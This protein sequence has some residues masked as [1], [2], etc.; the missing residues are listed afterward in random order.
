MKN[1]APRPA[2]ALGWIALGAIPGSLLRWAMANTMWAN[3]LGCFVVG[4]SGLLGKASPRRRLL[5]GL[6]FSGSLTTFSTW[7][8]EVITHLHQD[9][10]GGVLLQTS[11]DWALGLGALLLGAALHRSLSSLKG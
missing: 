11:R 10:L 7:V 6:G 8:M 5:V 2:V 1:T 4:V 3:T 9:G